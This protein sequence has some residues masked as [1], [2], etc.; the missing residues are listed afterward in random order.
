MVRVAINGFGRIGR[1]FFR[2]VLGDKSIDV[3]AIN[4]LTDAKTLAYLLKYDSVHGTLDADIKA[5]GSSVVVNGKEIP[6]T[7]IKD[8]A[9]LPWKKHKVDVVLESTGVFRAKPDVVKHLNAGAKRVVISAPPKGDDPIKQIVMGVNEDTLTK[10]DNVISLASCTTNCLTPLVKV[11][12]D[13]F[14]VSK[15]FMTTVHGYTNDQMIL[16]LPHK[17][18]RRGRAAA[19]NIIPTT[20]GATKAVVEVIPKLKGKIDGL[21]MRVPVADGSIVDLVAEL[22]RNV[23]PE[24]VNAAFKKASA[25]GRLK[26]ILQYTE[27]YIVSSD[28]INNPYSSIFDAKSTMVVNGNFVK[29]LSWYDNEWG[30]STRLGEFMKY[31]AK[32]M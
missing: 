14:G 25:S 3:V 28:V 8:P 10:D 27:D 13:S 21:A 32:K 31:V 1:N 16:D 2:A 26:G 17:D 29:V 24:E 22:K 20:T 18:P 30:Y 9:Q 7:A 11:L 19:V 23:T 6:V 12:D 5:K 15:A 4:D